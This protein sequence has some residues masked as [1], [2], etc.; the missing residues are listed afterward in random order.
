MRGEKKITLGHRA[1]ECQ[2]IWLDPACSTGGLWY[3]WLN[4]RVL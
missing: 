3:W 2:G 1:K 4:V